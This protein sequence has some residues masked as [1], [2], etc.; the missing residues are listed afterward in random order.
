M[1]AW[2]KFVSVQEAELGTE[3]IQ[4]WLKTLKVVRFDA[5]NLHLE[6][7]DAFQAMWFEE[8]IRQ[9]VLTKLLNNNNKRIKVHLSV[10]N[11]QNKPTKSKSKKD[12]QPEV[13]TPKF[14]LIF[15]ELDPQCT[16][17]NFVVA[18]ANQLS[19]QV[20]IKVSS[21]SHELGTFNPIY[22]H[23]STG[24]GKTH[25]LMAAGHELRNLGFNVIYSRAQTF[26]DHVVSAIRAGEMSTFR[27]AYRNIDILIIDDV[28]LFSRKA[29]TQE[30]F[31][32]TFNTLHIAGKQMILSANCAPGELQL[33]EPRLI[34]RFEWG[35]SL[36][37]ET[38]GTEELSQI[39]QQ[40]A[41]MMSY[42]LHPKVIE[43]LLETFKNSKSLSRA[44]EALV[45]RSHLNQ[46]SGKTNALLTAPLAKQILSDLILE[47]E[48]AALTPIR[49]IQEVAQA[50]GIRQEDI[51]GK[52][53]TRDC[54]LPRQIA[55]HLSRHQ[56]K[57]PFTKIGDLFGKDHSTVMSSVKLIQKGIDTDDREIAGTYHSILKKLKS[58]ISVA[59]K[60]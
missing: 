9:K 37:L 6:A 4:K 15:D 16:F 13:L 5:C 23:G 30:E 21:I 43:F 41:E 48:K 25:L 59:V 33:I 45:L 58:S 50:F 46:S 27:Q 57:M 18:E 49:I 7:K 31:F 26:T 54:V 32:H 38:P 34:S 44:L 11:T 17:K 60:Q 29:A 53:Q 56:L 28:H 47:E 55:M 24:A 40:K 35:I 8:H 51:L 22:L 14:T 20:V 10:A 36:S 42:P 12:K 1:Q 3:T 19:Y 52:A 2:E 39:V